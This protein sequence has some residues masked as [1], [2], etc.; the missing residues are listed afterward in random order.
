[1]FNN[2]IQFHFIFLFFSAKKWNTKKKFLKL[3]LGTS[4]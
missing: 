4:T 2:Y 1:M 3:D